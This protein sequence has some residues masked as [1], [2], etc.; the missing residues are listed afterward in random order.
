MP[1]TMHV[2]DAGLPQSGSGDLTER[3]NALENYLYM[4]LEELRYLLRNLSI[5]ENVNSASLEKYTAEITNPEE[6]NGTPRDMTAARL[7]AE[8]IIAQRSI[9]TPVLAAGGF[10]T[11]G[12]YTFLTPN[13]GLLLGGMVY[14]DTLPQ[15]NTPGRLFFK[16]AT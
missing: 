9:Q 13:E 1:G 10:R 4:L 16:K 2:I 5:Q 12:S 11:D 7:T 15:D 3:V 8:E 6:S 14:G